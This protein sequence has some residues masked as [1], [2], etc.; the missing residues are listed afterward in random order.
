MIKILYITNGITGPGGLERVLSIKASYL[1][2][3]LNYD[4]HIMT[5]NEEGK[6]N[7]YQFSPKIK[8]HTITTSNN[9]IQY[10]FQYITG[11]RRIVNKL[12][13]DVI[14]VCDDGLKGFFIP[15][16]LNNNM[17]IIY[18]RH[19][20]KLIETNNNQC[21]SKKSLIKVKWA[22]MEK[23]AKKFDRFI[24]LTEGNKKEWRSLK[25]ITVISNPLP[26]KSNEISTHK[27]K[28]AIC[29][30]KISYQKGQDILVKAW[31]KV[32]EQHPDWELHLYGNENTKFLNTKKLKNNIIFFP[33]EKEIQK[34][35][36]N[37]SIYVM[38]SRFEG[39]GM[40]L[41]EAM[42][43]GVPCVSFN[44]DYGPSDIIQDGTDGFLVEREN[45]QELAEKIIVL[46]ENEELRKQM[47][48][49]AKENVRRYSPEIIIKQWDGLFKSLVNNNEY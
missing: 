37:S 29:V 28:I 19:V 5:L 33:P 10:F 44:C 49:K 40:V 26:F 11:I 42:E 12:S 20:S 23:L 17:K 7:F 22:L 27:S 48:R 15:K 47:G 21:Y 43:F 34:K 13:P 32:H 8:I 31:E 16:L 45:P 36:F 9:K 39:F 41:I 4:V 1:A 2:D 18:E 38:S 3:K 14:S 6:S 24:V 30:G 35:Y 25:N 46:I